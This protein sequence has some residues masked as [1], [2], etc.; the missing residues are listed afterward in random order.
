MTWLLLVRTIMIPEEKI[1]ALFDNYLEKHTPEYKVST[2]P[3]VDLTQIVVIPSYRE[4]DYLFRTLDSLRACQPPSGTVEVIV[5]LNTSEKDSPAIQE[6]QK[7]CQRALSEYSQKY[8]VPWLQIYSLEAYQLRKKHFGAGMARKIGLDEA[9]RRFHA[10]HRP[11]G[12]ISCLDAD[13]PVA[14]NYF[15]AIEEWYQ[16][17]EHQAA[18]IYFEHPLD[19]IHFPSEVYEAITLY[20]L[21]LRYYLLALKQTGFP[22]ASHTIGSCMS[23][24]AIKYVQAG[25]MP[26]K[27]AGEDFYFLQKL[28]PLGGFGQITTTTVYPSPRPSNRVV[29]GTGASIR[30]HLNGTKK[31]GKTYNPEAF[32]D[33]H[34]F[35]SRAKELRAISP[36]KLEIWAY[37]LS[38]PLRSFLLNTNFEEELSI[39]LT[40]SNSEKT[41][42]KRFYATFNS[43]RIVKYLNYSHEH[44]YA[45]TDVF[46][47]AFTLMESI[48]E[49]IS[50]ILDEKDLL[51]KY[52]EVEKRDNTIII[53]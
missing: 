42:L 6:E 45:K 26:R 14:P 18:V 34:N 1:K 53:D 33:L 2:P 7:Q 21:H 30:E 52:R 51:L 38:G 11:N 12:I 44:F 13:S 39:I 22:Y 28:I 50:H 16:T 49:E 32:N 31:L 10:I 27:Q 23:F 20:E 19:G 48:G 5:V 35:F 47:A 41:F 8:Q 17:P 29:F 4:K 3:P 9:I 15:T 36:D 24:R 37:N 43:F 46:E 40:N 25:G